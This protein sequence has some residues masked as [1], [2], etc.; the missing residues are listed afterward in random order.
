[1]RNKQISGITLIALVI[2]II[3]LL[4][5]AGVA[6]IT[7]TGENGILN[8]TITAKEN[9]ATATAQER[10]QLEVIASYD[11]NGKLQLETLKSN[12]AKSIPEAIVKGDAFPITVIL[13]GKTFIVDGD[14]NVKLVGT[15]PEIKESNTTITL[16]DGETIPEGGVDVGVEL[17]IDFTATIEGG[18][19]AISPNVPYIT[20]GTEKEVKFTIIGSVNGETYQMEKIVDLKDYYKKTEFGATDIAKNPVEFYGSAVEK[21]YVKEKASDNVKN[22]VTTW[23]IFY[24]GKEPNGEEENIYLIADDYIPYEATPNGKDGSKIK[25]NSTKY[26]LSFNNVYNDYEGGSSWILEN[27][28][29]KGWLNKYFNYKEIGQNGIE[30][31]PNQASKNTNIRSVA[32]MMDTNIWSNYAGVGAKYAIGGPP[33]EMFCTSYKESHSDSNISCDV[34][35]TKGYTYSNAKGLLSD[36]DEIYIKPDTK[37]ANAM[38][39]AAPSSNGPISIAYAYYNGGINNNGYTIGLPGFRPIVCLDSKV[40]LEKRAERVYS[41]V[42]EDNK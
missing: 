23:R 15:S 1:M 40:K 18:T 27:S 26:K 31:Y 16:K 13:D 25:Q 38:W 19:I 7:L 3:V 10:I 30:T 37:L 34:N 20:N 28:L 24:V 22:A 36:C 39:L 42:L 29:A 11:E 17:K 4:I 41:I 6:I 9:T 2:T 12:I 8:K 32:Y 21:Y 5:L 33:I 14:G 35:D